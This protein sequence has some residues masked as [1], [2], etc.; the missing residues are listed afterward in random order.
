M[1]C[2]F[3]F[4]LCVPLTVQG[5]LNSVV[6][7]FRVFLVL[8][9]ITRLVQSRVAD[10]TRWIRSAQPLL[11][12]I[13]RRLAAAGYAGDGAWHR[14]QRFLGRLPTLFVA[15][16]WV[17]AVRPREASDADSWRVRLVL[18]NVHV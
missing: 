11:L 8:R 10:K 18:D 4:L 14:P 16:R 12:R 5:W 17:R 2:C 7:R 1:R 15:A 6:P 13:L 9:E 3:G